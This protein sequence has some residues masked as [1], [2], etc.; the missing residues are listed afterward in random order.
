M[1][2]KIWGHTLVLLAP[3]ECESTSDLCPNIWLHSSSILAFRLIWTPNA[4]WLCIDKKICEHIIRICWY[5]MPIRIEWPRIYPSGT[6]GWLQL[7]ILMSRFKIGLKKCHH[8]FMQKFMGKMS[9][10]ICQNGNKMFLKE[11]WTDN[12]S[13][14]LDDVPFFGLN[15]RRTWSFCDFLSKLSLHQHFTH[16]GVP[17]SPL[18]KKL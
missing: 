18:K 14:Q 8:E 16:F 2:I 12:N 4:N 9:S 11:L 13:K 1:Y 3:I 17:F 7:W 15:L 6:W 5:R 10:Q